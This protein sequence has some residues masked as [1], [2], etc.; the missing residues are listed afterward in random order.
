MKLEFKELG[1]DIQTI[2]SALGL[3]YE[4]EFDDNEKWRKDKEN[5]W[6]EN[7]RQSKGLYD[8]DVLLKIP[9]NA[10]RVYPKYTRSK[11][12][13][14]RSKL[15]SMLLPENDKNYAIE[16][17]PKPNLSKAVLGEIV[18][19]L[20]A[21]K[22]QKALMQ[23]QSTGT[24]VKP[25]EVTKEELE[26]KINEYAKARCEKMDK[27]I[28]DQ[29]TEIKYN[30]TQEDIIKSGVRFGTGIAKGVL[31]QTIEE[32]DYEETTEGWK[33]IIVS[34]RLP[35]IANVR[36]WDWYPD[37]SACELEDCDFVWER[38]ILNKHQLRKLTLRE[39]FFSDTIR[40]YIKDHPKG[41]ATYKDWELQLETIDKAKS[42]ETRIGKY[43]ILERWGFID[44]EDLRKAGKDIPDDQLDIEFLVNIWIIG[45]KVIK[46]SHGTLPVKHLPY[47]LFYYDKDETSIFGTGL[48]KIIRDTQ[49]TICGAMR[50]TLNN[51]AKVSGAMMEVNTDLLSPDEDIE[52]VAP[53][54]IWKR[55]GR[56]AEA[57]SP[58]VRPVTFNSHIADLLTIL[59]KAFYL[60]DVEISIPLWMHTE[61]DK[62]QKQTLGE[63]SLK[64]QSSTVSIRDIIK[65]YDKCNEGVIYALYN[66]NMEFNPNEDIK[67]DFNI[68][69]KGSTSLVLNELKMHALNYF[70][71]TLTPEE[72][73]YVKTG[74]F[75]KE[76][77]RVFYLKPKDFIRTEEEVQA[78]LASQRDANAE[79]LA[80]ATA[81]AKIIYDLAKAKHMEAKAEKTLKDADLDILKAV[82]E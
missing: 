22:Q 21:I 38:H 28:E 80:K 9:K 25:E 18:E 61:P 67:G 78:F 75:L 76:R 35:D 2:I 59:E 17:T 44:G 74:E 54:R 50:A 56:L 68:K 52:D 26:E 43:E 79:A 47:F 81:E 10:S 64:W 19:T 5:E 42:Q 70:A 36:V 51:A 45:S 37:M 29:L 49:L 66:W 34:K 62:S 77:A 30:E 1:Y 53:D 6:L 3:K 41:N 46:I 58:A 55:G 27:Q 73:V 31:S 23:T 48:P 20:T 40:E 65:S 12:I 71:T 32:G 33:S 11:E 63:A 57:Q 24:M 72:R 4:S 69:A 15:N 8:P 60:G 7:L 39:D 14:L 82:K 16:P 13:I